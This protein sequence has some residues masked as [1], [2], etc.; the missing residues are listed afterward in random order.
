M[1]QPNHVTVVLDDDPTG[2]QTVY[3]VDVLTDWHEDVLA[4]QFGRAASG[5]DDRAFYILTNS[6]ALPE[7]EAATLLTGICR[8]LNAAAERSGKTFSLI[9]RGDSTLRGHFPAEPLAVETA[10]NVAFDR[11]L[12]CPFFAE[13][14]RVTLDGVHYVRE[15]ETLRPVAE[16]PF[17]QDHVFGYRSSNLRAWVEEKTGG[18][19]R[20]E[21]V[22]LLRLEDLRQNGPD[23]VA[24]ALRHGPKLWVADA[25]TLADVAMLQ[26][27]C[28]RLEAE[29]LRILYR[30]AASFVQ[31]Y[32][33][34]ETRP[35]LRPDEL[36][37]DTSAGGLVV[38]GSYVPKTTAQLAALRSAVPNATFLELDVAQL[39]ND[40]TFETTVHE[41]ISA[42]NATLARG[43]TAVLFT[44]RELLTDDDPTT[45]LSLNRRVSEALV[46]VVRGLAVAPRFFIAKGGITSSDVATHGLGVRRA[47][48]LGQA[49]PGVPVWQLGP[50]SRFPGGRY[51]VFPGNV[52]GDS[53]LAELVHSLLLAL[54]SRSSLSRTL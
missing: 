39:L 46:H 50:E 21:D 1:T 25:D 48:V 45:N 34:L 11:W 4:E 5:R 41:A 8:N 33:G 44:S 53:A 16:T 32:L 30:T 23:Y 43:E 29:G 42:V 51:V 31:A 12:L 49:L 35:P 52:G 37:S 10:L 40:A 27:G 47:R 17:A 28:K 38:V 6:R 13:G 26:A 36:V 20:A 18:T 7:T 22:G 24:D 2:T 9:L 14:G 54:P 3:G 19:V 15:V